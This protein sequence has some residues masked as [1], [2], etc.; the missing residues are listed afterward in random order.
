MFF[1]YFNEDIFTILKFF[2]SYELLRYFQPIYDKKFK[3]IED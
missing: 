2:L 3:L 1:R